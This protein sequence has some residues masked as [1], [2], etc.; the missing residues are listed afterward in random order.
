[1]SYPK[2]IPKVVT[3]VFC[4]RNSTYVLISNAS[5]KACS[6]IDKGTWPIVLRICNSFSLEIGFAVRFGTY[7]L[8]S[9]RFDKRLAEC[10]LLAS[11]D[12]DYALAEFATCNRGSKHGFRSIYNVFPCVRS[13]RI[14]SCNQKRRS[15]LELARVRIYS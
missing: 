10:S 2:N 7:V 11:I 9:D 1:M 15:S 13:S 12:L 8:N 3:T 14:R 5:K 4:Q 6:Q